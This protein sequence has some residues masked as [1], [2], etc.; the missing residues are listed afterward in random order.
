MRHEDGYAWVFTNNREVIS[1]YKPTRE[2][3]FLKEFLKDFNGILVSDFYTA[4]DSI[5]CLQQKCLIHLIRDLN[6]D[7]LKNPFDGEF[8]FMTHNFSTLLQ[9]I[10]KT[11]DKYGLKRR[12]LNKHKKEVNAF[13]KMLNACK[14]S[15]ETASHYKERFLKNIDKLFQFLD[16]DNVS[17][18]NNNAEHAIKLLATHTNKKIKLFSTTRIDEYLNIMSVYQT[19]VYHDISFFK[20]LLS[21]ERD[22]D[23]YLRKVS[24][25]PLKPI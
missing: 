15:S 9:N 17:W 8:K 25:N 11:I 3:G 4:Y 12:H 20:F 18:N 23:K 7:L 21:R 13:F 1:F 16:H 5:N 19:C 14:Y 10:V 22:L 2:G 6:D 24:K